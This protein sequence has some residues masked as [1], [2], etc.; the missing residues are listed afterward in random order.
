MT[1]DVPDEGYFRNASCVVD[2]V[3]T[4]VLLWQFRYLCWWTINPR[5]HH[6]PS[7]KKN[8]LLWNRFHG[9]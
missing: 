1:L 9:K 6:P 2:L 5:G 8:L 3:S 7:S 4:F